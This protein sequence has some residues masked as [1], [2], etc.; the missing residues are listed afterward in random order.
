MDSGIAEDLVESNPRIPG[1]HMP[2]SEFSPWTPARTRTAVVAYYL[3]FA[4]AVR[5]DQ[6]TTHPGLNESLLENT[7]DQCALIQ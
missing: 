6:A 4:G 7:N 3:T 1:F 5:R 2:Q